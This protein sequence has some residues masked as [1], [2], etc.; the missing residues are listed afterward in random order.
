M[1]TASAPHEILELIHD[2]HNQ[3]EIISGSAHLIGLSP[4]LSARDR[5]DLLN[6]RQAAQAIAGRSDESL[7]LLVDRTAREAGL[8]QRSL[9]LVPAVGVEVV[10]HPRRSLAIPTGDMRH[11][12]TCGPAGTE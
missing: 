6:I 7:A 1:P 4:T 9:A 8:E 10:R 2:I 11:G 12:C 3:L 5:Q